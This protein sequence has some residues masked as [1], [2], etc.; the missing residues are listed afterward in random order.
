MIDLRARYNKK[1][2][3]PISKKNGTYVLHY[4]GPSTAKFATDLAVID[5]DY[6]WHTGTPPNGHGWVGVAYHYAIGRDGQVYWLNDESE[7]LNH[8]GVPWANDRAIAVQLTV[9][10]GDRVSQQ[11]FN[12][13][14]QFLELKKVKPRFLSTHREAPRTTACPGALIQRWVEDYRKINSGARFEGVTKFS[15]N[16][17]DEASVLSHLVR[18]IAAGMR[19]KGVQVLGKPVQGDSLWIQL[20]GS[21][22][23]IHASVFGV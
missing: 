11:Q 20:D 10:E 15:G 16:V 23:F 2:A 4:N 22:D 12:A 13:L 8:A 1:G 3:W 9:G 14:A 6:A 19:V 18:P 17:R 21:T 7:R 5:N